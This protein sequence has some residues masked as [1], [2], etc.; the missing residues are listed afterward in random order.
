LL[1]RKDALH[2][3]LHPYVFFF[4]FLFFLY[5]KKLSLKI[6]KTDCGCMKKNKRKETHRPTAIKKNC[7]KNEKK[8]HAP[9]T[10]A[11][12]AQALKIDEQKK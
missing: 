5:N 7:H 10:S 3:L 11:I 8:R 9:P 6:K 1:V 2:K 4:I 12:S